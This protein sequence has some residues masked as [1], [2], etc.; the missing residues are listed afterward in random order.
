MPAPVPTPDC[1][2]L[3]IAGPCRPRRFTM[4]RRASVFSH[5]D[6]YGTPHGWLTLTREFSQAARRRQ[7]AEGFRSR[8]DQLRAS[9]RREHKYGASNVFWEAV[10]WRKYLDFGTTRQ[11]TILTYTIRHQAPSKERGR[12]TE[13]RPAA[14]PPYGWM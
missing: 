1:W 14:A 9:G 7:E 10:P 6:W 12:R 2:P 11:Y 4:V 3:Q 5:H 13:L 8:I